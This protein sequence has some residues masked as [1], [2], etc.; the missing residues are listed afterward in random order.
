MLHTAMTTSVPTTTQNAMGPSR[1]CRPAW[2][3]GVARR[4]PPHGCVGGPVWAGMGGIDGYGSA[5]Q[6]TVEAF[7]LP[8]RSP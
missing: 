7:T 8:L 5:V 2:A 4:P 1:S 6:M 3:K